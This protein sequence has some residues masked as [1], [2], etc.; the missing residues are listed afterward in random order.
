MTFGSVPNLPGVVI[1]E[2][3]NSILPFGPVLD[4]WYGIGGVQISLD[5][6]HPLSSALQV[7]FQVDVP[8]NASGEVGIKNDGWWGLPVFP[9]TYNTSFWV[10]SDGFRWNYTITHFDV[11]LRDNATDEIFI[12]NTVP[13]GGQ[14][15]PFPYQYT[16][17]AT[18]LV[19]TVEAPSI[20]NSFAI[21][22]DAAEA[23]GQ[24]LYF[25][26]LSLFGETYNDRP[27][28]LRKDLAEQLAALEPK[29]LRFP[30]GN[31]LEGYSIQRRWKWWETIGPLKD[32]PGRPGDWTYYNT[33]GLGLLEYLL[34]CE[35]FGMAPLL[36]VYAGFS[37]DQAA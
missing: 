17:Y 36:A 29:F 35:D 11:S 9:Q 22:F 16:R 5:I 10:Q 12:S 4:G 28:G 32:R 13:V 27:N 23:A 24:T 7:A 15:G 33:D 30:G 25:D 1:T 21:T 3:E 37:L 31:N 8:L 2:A 6:L 18:T 14:R 26:L 34:W 20:N 19:N